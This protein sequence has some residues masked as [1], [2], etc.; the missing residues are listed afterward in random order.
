M[1]DD[2][3]PDIEAA[4]AVAIAAAGLTPPSSIIADGKLRR[5]ASARKA[6]DDS[7]WYVLFSG[8]PAA[9]VFGCWRAGITQT[10]CFRERRSLTTDERRAFAKYI[11]EARDTAR[12][13]LAERRRS[14]RARAGTDWERAKPADP[15]HPY[16]AAKAVGVY[17]IR[18]LDGD[19]LIPL[20]DTAGALHGLQHISANGDKKF[21]YGTAKQGHFHLIG[22]LGSRLISAEGYATAASIHEA[23]GDAVVVAFDAGN[24]RPVVEAVRAKFPEEAIVIAGDN[25]QSG[26]GQWCAREA[27]AAVGGKVVICPRVKDFNDLANIEGHDAVREAL[28]EPAEP[29][30]EPESIDDAVKRLAKLNPIAFDRVAEAEAK[31]LGCKLGTLREEVRRARRGNGNGEDSAQGCSFEP[32]EP[33]PWPNSVDGADLL[34]AISAE[35]SNYVKFPIGGAD[36]VAL[37]T[38]HTYAHDAARISPILAITSAAPECGKTT[39]LTGVS[40]LAS[41]ALS[42]SNVTSS[43]V[44]R[45]IEMWNPTL[46]IDEAD[47]FLPDNEELRGVLNSGHNRAMAYILRNVGDDHEPRAF[48]TWAPKAI[49]LIGKLPATLESRSI[50]IELRRIALA[51]SVKELRADRLEHFKP[52]VQKAA[53]WTADNIERLRVANPTMPGGFVGRRADNWRPLFAI[54]ETVGGNWP[55]RAKAAALALSA[56]DAGQTAGIMLLSD[57]RDIFTDNAA[58]ELAS[59]FLVGALAEMEG[60]PWPE[61]SSGKPLTSSRMAKLLVPFKIKPTKWRDGDDTVR[62]YQKNAFV[63]IW[64]RYLRSASADQNA[65][66]PHP[67]QSTAYDGNQNATNSNGVAASSPRKPAECGP[68]G[69]VADEVPAP[70]QE[71]WTTTL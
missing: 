19:L 10:W 51:E 13:E 22:E 39:L 42:A 35:L 31:K 44:F 45:A 41:R 25:D 5:F 30:G 65:T 33:E 69:V 16:L 27:A 56:A 21:P 12:R 28:S 54:A 37:W 7:G 68:C 49:A 55:D 70:G 23:T 50:E 53:R 52:L 26:T 61:F 40:A 18:Q 17:G 36:A 46:L 1:R 43:T 14:A 47:S 57:I 58:D 9:G 38:M 3:N 4:F 62:G 11:R 6:G 66:T 71:S 64:A 48:R 2:D 59:T 60:R 8:D 29:E 67:K 34:D 20:R 15:N 63:E 24:L 32:S